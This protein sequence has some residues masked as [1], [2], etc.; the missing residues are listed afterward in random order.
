MHRARSS[1]ELAELERELRKA[2]IDATRSALRARLLIAVLDEPKEGTGPTELDGEHA[3]HVRILL[4]DLPTQ[5]PLLRMRRPVDP[6]WITP[7]RRPR[8]ARELDGCKLGLD[9]RDAV[10]AGPAPPAP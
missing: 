7:G 1:Q 5:K 6:S 9:L 4:A 10:T 8:Y 2:P 3:H